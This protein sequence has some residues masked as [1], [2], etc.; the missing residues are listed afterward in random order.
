MDDKNIYN[1]RGSTKY[2]KVIVLKSC[3]WGNGEYINAKVFATTEIPIS[4]H[5]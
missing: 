3:M 5:K 4:I 2:T 1:H